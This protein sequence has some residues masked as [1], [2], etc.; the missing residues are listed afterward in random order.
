MGAQFVVEI[1][2]VVTE[3]EADEQMKVVVFESAVRRFLLNHSDFRADI[4]DLTGLPQG[5]TGLEAWPDI[6]V[7]LTRAPF[8]SIAVIPG[9]RHRQRQRARAGVRHELRQPRRGDRRRIVARWA[10]ILVTEAG[11]VATVAEA[12][13]R[14]RP[15][16]SQPIRGDLLVSRLPT[17]S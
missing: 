2:K 10:I 6:L 1:G 5:P 9:T 16:S 13:K 4:T 7:R 12:M 14:A 15:R 11:R 8:I 17:R 3:L